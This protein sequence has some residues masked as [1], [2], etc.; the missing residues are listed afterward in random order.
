M[1]MR[2]ML[3][4][5]SVVIAGSRWEQGKRRAAST[6]L[7]ALGLFAVA[8]ASSGQ[9]D[10]IAA[11]AAGDLRQL[12]TLLA[13][14]ADVDVRGINGVTALFVASANGH[15]NV[16]RALI[17]ANADLNSKVTAGGTALMIA[18]Q[19]GHLEVFNSCLLLKL[20]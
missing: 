15:L 3:V 13:S 11:A 16:V 7:A 9:R 8:P 14:R 17:A 2:L 5:A 18:S 20:T 12:E 4:L 1:L 6:V 10:L 19:N